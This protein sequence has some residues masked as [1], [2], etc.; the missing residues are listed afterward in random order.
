MNIAAGTIYQTT[1]HC[2][3]FLAFGDWGSECVEVLESLATNICRA[4]QPDD[5][6]NRREQPSFVLA[7]G[8]NFYLDGVTSHKDPRIAQEWISIFGS[9]SVY[10]KPKPLK[11]F[12]APGNHDYNPASGI[13][14]QLHFTDDGA[15]V[16]GIWNM[17]SICTGDE[18]QGDVKLPPP[19]PRMPP[20]PP[21][22]NCQLRVQVPSEPDFASLPTRVPYA[23]HT[24]VYLNPQGE[25]ESVDFF[26]IDTCAAQWSVRDRFPQVLGEFETQRR[27]LEQSLQRS[28]ARWKIVCG[29]HPLYTSGRGHQDEARC[30]RGGQYTLVSDPSYK[31]RQGLDM[32]ALFRRHEVD[33]YLCGHEHVF[34]HSH[35]TWDTEAGQKS[36]H[37]F[38]LGNAIESFFWRGQYKPPTATD[39]LSSAAKSFA[40]SNFTTKFEIDEELVEALKNGKASQFD[41]H[42]SLFSIQAHV[43]EVSRC[44]GI[45][46]V[47]VSHTTFLVEIV[48]IAGKVVHTTAVSKPTS[49]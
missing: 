23:Q 33:I 2:F 46:R 31:V 45:A 26:V 39:G 1:S 8:D 21:L 25:E 18:A 12:V 13:R 20:P 5:R 14:G 40:E 36:T 24:V 47:E 28:K 38:V 29:H 7:L 6:D 9:P 17:G 30:M 34:Q 49:C 27:W 43:D 32:E 15:N 19:P 44:M 3:S 41:P 10:C 37:H 35:D 11:W 48:D 22:S 4:C 16:N 42:R